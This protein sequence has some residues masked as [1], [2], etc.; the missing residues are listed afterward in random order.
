MVLSWALAGSGS[1]VASALCLRV[2]YRRQSKLEAARIVRAIECGDVDELAMLWAERAYPDA[3]YDWFG[4]PALIL[5]AR[6]SL[7]ATRFLLSRGVD[8]DERGAG[9]MTALM[10]AAAA[11]D[12]DLC[13]VLLE[14]GADPD[15]RDAFGREAAWFADVGGKQDIARWLRRGALPELP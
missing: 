1:F 10:Y 6:R 7:N 8:V 13:R 15:A 9:W 14:C 11:G 3:V 2:W 5:A 12:Q 4:D